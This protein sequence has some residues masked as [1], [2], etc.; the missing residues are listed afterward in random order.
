[1]SAKI[2]D[3]MDWAAIDGIVYSEEDNPHAILGPHIIEQGVLIQTFFPNAKQ[4]TVRIINS[5]SLYLMEMQDEEGFF[6]VL[7]PSKTIPSYIYIVEDK[8]GQTYEVHD[9]Y[10]FE[11]QITQKE[12]M[13]FNCGLHYKMYEK[14][15]AHRMVIKGI[16]GVH[17]AV[18]APSALRVSV[19]GNFNHWDGRCHQMRRLWESG[20]FELFIPG[21][22]I[23]DLYKFEIKFKGGMLELKADPYANEAQLRPDTASVVA[24]LECFDW[25]DEEWISNR[26]KQKLDNQPLSIYEVHLG[27]WRRPEDKREFYNYKELAAMIAEYVL[28]MGYTHIELMPVME[29]PSDAYWGYQITGY[30]APTSRYG[31]STDFM[32]FMNYMHERGIGVILD[33][34]PAYF[35]KDSFG[36]ANFDGTC[37]YEHLDPRQGSHPR[38]DILIYNYARPQ[39]RNFLIANAVFWVEMYHADGIRIEE[40]ASMLYLDYGKNPGEWLPNIYGGNE[41]LDAIVFLKQLSEVFK[42]NANGAILIAKES[43]AW[44]MVTADTKKNGLGLDYKWNTGWL[45]DF[46]GYMRND[47]Y[48]R[49][50]HYGE[51]TLSMIY[52]YSEK[53]ILA[54]SHD[55]VVHGKGSMI[56]KMPGNKEKQFANLRAVYGFMYT[57]PG[58]KLLFMGQDIGQYT[59]WSEQSSIEWSILEE[60]QHISFKNYVKALNHIYRNEPALY[61][62]DYKTEGFD[63]INNI[64]AN[65]NIVVFTRNTK[66]QEDTLIVICN[67]VPVLQENYKIGVPFQG[68][69]KEIFSSD[70][71]EYGGEN[72]INRR[73]KQSR[74]EECDGRDHSIKVTVPP[75]GITILKFFLDKHKMSNKKNTKRSNKTKSNLKD[76]LAAQ[77]ILADEKR[78]LEKSILAAKQVEEAQIQTNSIKKI[79]ETDWR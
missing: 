51:L 74:L 14:L 49:S 45:N 63:W 43:S 54:F 40:A 12:A 73:M 39:V 72:H 9:A 50:S 60:K 18:W 64:S 27:S 65:E 78:E 25:K 46:L 44:P 21:V 68:K 19:V 17:F 16:D 57:H 22:K 69:Y 15:G 11:P 58:K 30:Y 37:L 5:G 20:I 56:N 47:P 62:L 61:E 32:F 48:V 28:E 42:V 10:S 52:A 77:V 7:L 71:L 35:P 55:E 6:A 33:W 75:L 66:M 13:K 36:L 59:E 23:G 41:N 34:V 67:F 31:S 79:D 2:Y 29:H 70:C 76:R 38:F 8:D 26:N 24:D 1:M 4:V 53:F 3:L